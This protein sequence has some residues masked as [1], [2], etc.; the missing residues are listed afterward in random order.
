MVQT[1]DKDLTFSML[2]DLKYTCDCLNQKILETSNMQLRQNYINILNETFIEHKQ[3]F[4]IMTHR[5]WYQPQVAEQQELTQ[6]INKISTMQ[7]QGVQTMNAAQYQQQ[8][9]QSI[10]YDRKNQGH[11]L[12]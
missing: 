11:Q 8:Y 10:M 3:L 5:G 12:Y 9:M 2:N 6:F 4:D 1:K 7:I